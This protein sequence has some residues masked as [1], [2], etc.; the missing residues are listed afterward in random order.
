[1]R[2]VD[3]TATFIL[4]ALIGFLIGNFVAF[5]GETGRLRSGAE[6]GVMVIDGGIYT[7]K[8]LETK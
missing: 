7:V 1:M 4:T 5:L 6:H 3:S 8:P 2:A